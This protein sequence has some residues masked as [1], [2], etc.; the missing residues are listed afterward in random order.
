MSYNPYYIYT[1]KDVDSFTQNKTINKDVTIRGEQL[2]SLIGVEKIIGFLTINDSS[3][4]SL[5]DLQ[6][7]TDSFFISSYNI[8]SRLKTL[9]NLKSVG[10]DLSLRYSNVEDLGELR[11]VGGKL[12]LRDTKITNLGKLNFVGGDLFL[13]SRFKDKLD[14][15]AIKILGKVQYWNDNR[16][17]NEVITPKEQLGLISHSYNIPHL[18]DYDSIS[19]SAFQQASL[20]QKEFF[21]LFKRH[22]IN[23][24]FLDIKGNY[25]Y[26]SVLYYDLLDEYSRDKNINKLQKEFTNLGKYYPDIT[27][28]KQIVIRELQLHSDYETAW[29]LINESNY[30]D[31]IKI[32]EFEKKLN[33]SLLEGELIVRLSGYSYLTSFGQKNIE[34]IKPFVTRQLEIYEI[35]KGKKFFEVFIKNG[36][37]P[38]LLDETKVLSIESYSKFIE[39][40]QYGIKIDAKYNFDYYKQFFLFNYDEINYKSSNDKMV[41]ENDPSEILRIVHYAIINQFQYIVKEAENLFR[42]SIGL[43]KVGEGWISEMELYYSIK[44]SFVEDEVISQG[45]PK[46]LGLQRFDIYLPKYNIAIEYQGKQHFE[47]VS[48]FG[49]K[50]GLI[51]VQENDR[52]KRELCA[53]NNCYLIEVL[54]DY[55]IEEVLSQIKSI[56]QIRG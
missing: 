3:I 6:E 11:E 39:S 46:W 38:Y 27:N 50:E 29:N 16:N 2:Q 19:F 47:E 51:K 44:E 23:G 40:V 17:K 37:H 34:K 24:E 48:V 41:S 45:K 25:R 43:P 55:D 20:E 15:S 56:I 12:S 33:R 1:Q 9:G 30:V 18:S 14:L 32:I 5:G 21:R 53:L 36:R 28:Q 52:K 13:P 10:G 22:F 4:E 8:F 42:L 7:I 26:I 31:Y 49:G 54:P 35:E